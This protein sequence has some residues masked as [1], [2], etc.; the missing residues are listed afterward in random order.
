MEINTNTRTTLM[1]GTEGM[2]RLQA[3]HVLVVGL[4]GVGGAALEMLARAGVGSLTIVDA[5]A[6]HVTNVNRQL[7]A[8]HSTIGQPKAEA[9]RTRLMDINPALKLTIYS[10]FLEEE[11]TERILDSVH[12]DFVVDAID[13]ISPK[14]FLIAKCVERGLPIVSSM[15]SGGKID[16]TKIRYAD[17]SK[18]AYCSL[19]KVVRTRL[20]KIGIRRGVM[21]VYST[22]EPNKA[23]VLEVKDEKYKRTTTGTVSYMPNLFG[24]WIAA[25]VI[26]KLVQ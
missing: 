1:Y 8:L 17:I 16:P 14:V 13:T 21:C 15:G 22:E 19:A 5:D 3:A 4:G 25:H 26:N 6:V 10:E 2:N 24:G 12:F 11:N 23:A 7:V 20:A 18:T 9:W